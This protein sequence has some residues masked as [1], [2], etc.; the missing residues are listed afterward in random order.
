MQTHWRVCVHANSCAGVFMR[1]RSKVALTF[2]HNTVIKKHRLG[3][4]SA[5]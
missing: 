4:N 3:L 2:M 5:T 1:R